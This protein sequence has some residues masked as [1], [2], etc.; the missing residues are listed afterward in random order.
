MAKEKIKEIYKKISIS[1]NGPA[2]DTLRKFGL[3]YKVIFGLSIGQIKNI[4][5][6]YVPN[7]ELA[8][9]LREKNVREAHLLAT[10]LDVLSEN[11]FDYIVN[12]VNTADNIE[13]VEQMA[14]N[15]LAPLNFAYRLAN[16]FIKSDKEYVISTAYIL[17]SVLFSSDKN[18]FCEQY[19]TCF[20]YSLKH[21]Q[22]NS[23]HVRKSVARAL[24][25]LA[26]KNEI[27]KN[28][29]LNHCII[30]KKNNT[31]QTDFVYEEV[32]PLV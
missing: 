10:M 32:V 12:L 22:N 26:S 14:Y 25:K 6:D 20:E 27:I 13:I 21:S 4:A 16:E 28:E 1:Q 8:L 30:I 3:Q 29:V 7:H 17:Y 11:D 19:N 9:K 5:R 31:P 24:R 23:L 15:M 2:S 18:N